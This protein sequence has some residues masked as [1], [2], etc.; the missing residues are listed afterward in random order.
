MS[1]SYAAARLSHPKCKVKAVPDP[2]PTVKFGPDAFGHTNFS[3]GTDEY[4]KARLAYHRIS[5]SPSTRYPSFYEGWIRD[6]SND[7]HQPDGGV[8]SY[9][10]PERYA[11]HMRAL[12]FRHRIILDMVENWQ[13]DDSEV[14]T[15]PLERNPEVLNYLGYLDSIL[16]HLLDD[17][18]SFLTSKDS[19]LVL[20]PDLASHRFGY[21]DQ[22]LII[23]LRLGRH[24]MI[25]KGTSCI[26]TYSGDIRTGAYLLYCFT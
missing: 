26:A 24:D 18:Q 20:D 25:E 5:Y 23:E 16:Q 12:V 7:S 4:R 14:L 15:G 11:G 17:M 3:K 2:K 9:Y 8:L 13:D 19:V 22:Y 10:V 1:R 6:L 21:F